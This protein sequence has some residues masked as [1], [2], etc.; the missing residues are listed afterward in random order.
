MISAF[1][2]DEKKGSKEREVSSMQAFKDLI[3]YLKEHTGRL[4]FCLLLLAGVIVFALAWPKL[5]QEAIDGPIVEQLQVPHGERDF[6]DLLLYGLAIFLIQ[7]VSIVLQY[8]QYVK[9]EIIGQDIILSIKRKL[10]DHVL[11]LDISFFDT[12]PVGRLMARIESD[13]ESLR[14]LFTNTVVVVVGDLLLMAGI[15]TWMFIRE[16]RLALVLFLFAPVLALMVWIFHK[17]TT[18]RFL[19][20]RKRMAEI[21]AS[22][23][24]LIQGVSIIQIFHRGSWARKKVWRANEVKFR[25]DAYVNIAVC[26]FFNVLFFMEYVKIGL[27]LLLGAYWGLTPGTIVFFVLMIW[28]EFDPIARTADQL[29]SFQKGIAGS[30]RIFGLLSVKPRLLDPARPVAWSSLTKGVSFENVWFSYSDNE[31]W[32]LRDVSFDIPVGKR[33]ALAGVTGGGKS[34]VISLLLRLYDVQKGRITVDGIDIRQIKTA[35]LRKR[36]ALVLQDIILFPGD[37]TSNIGLEA[38]EIPHERIV[39]SAKIVAAD[40]VIQALP[41]GYR[42]EVSEKG[43]NFSRGERQLLSFARALAIEPDLL[44]LDEATS[45]VDPETERTIQSSL[46]KLMAGRTSL[47]IAHRLATILDADQI[48]V[49]RHGEIVERGTHTELILKDGYYSKLFHLQF[50]NNRRTT[51][52]A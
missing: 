8:Y 9:L 1:Y 11:S 37:V 52:N 28:K 23:T 29:G 36:F 14:L 20:V 38:E 35:E 18:H 27:I 32:V 7:I 39:S 15:Y 16:W 3:P 12:N 4:V 41:E 46:K 40:Q 6:S 5:I 25:E 24:E 48:L 22:L 13:T 31:E 26:I 43:A 30:R 42:T 19:E 50:K 47:I 17:L 33:V 45:S 21:T 34:T 2:E 44:I 51:A 49:I 10:F